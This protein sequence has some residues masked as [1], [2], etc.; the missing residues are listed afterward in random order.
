[1]GH[2]QLAMIFDQASTQYCTPALLA[3]HAEDMVG[4]CIFNICW[5]L[6]T[7]KV[8][9]R[10]YPVQVPL[11]LLSR[12]HTPAWEDLSNKLITDINPYNISRLCCS[13][14]IKHARHVGRDGGNAVR[15]WKYTGLAVLVVC[16]SSLGDHRTPLYLPGTNLVAEA[17]PLAATGLAT[18]S[19]A[20][21]ISVCQTVG[22]CEGGQLHDAPGLVTCMFADCPLHPIINIMLT[23]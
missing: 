16:Q 12:K 1:M 11:R 13:H 6:C 8:Y 15:S 17:K 3:M 22:G 9:C 20:H 23:D 2:C 18:W 14:M 10:Q 4:Q 19:A 7:M 21:V 5:Q